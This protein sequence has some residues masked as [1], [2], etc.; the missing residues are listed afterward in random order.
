MKQILLK[1]I[2][3]SGF[4][5]TLLYFSSGM[6]GEFYA[7]DFLPKGEGSVTF[8][9]NLNQP[10]VD[11]DLKSTGQKKFKIVLDEKIKNKTAVK[12]FDIVGNLILEDAIE[13][14]DG[15]QKTYNFAHIKSQL[16]VVEVGN[17]K[18][19]KTKSIYAD[20]QGEKKEIKKAGETA[21]T[22]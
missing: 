17:S 8:P 6:V 16:F 11:F 13:P 14:K 3:T 9:K 18:Y 1:K 4:L 2:F 21:S 12:I 19:N 5:F 20:P 15:K 22:E 7:Q 10:D